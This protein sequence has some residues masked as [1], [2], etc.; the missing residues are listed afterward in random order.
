MLGNC[1]RPFPERLIDAR[2]AVYLCRKYATVESVYRAD[3]VVGEYILQHPEQNIMMT[4]DCRFMLA[5]IYDAGRLQG[6]REER[7]KRK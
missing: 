7:R 5:T 6:I 1:R 3:E 4:Q 2:T